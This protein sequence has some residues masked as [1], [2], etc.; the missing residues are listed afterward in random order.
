MLLRETNR[1]S[2]AEEL[3]VSDNEV[4]PEHAQPQLWRQTPP[5][6]LL[7]RVGAQ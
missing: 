5:S 1:L 6:F 7:R 4:W 2:F 3:V